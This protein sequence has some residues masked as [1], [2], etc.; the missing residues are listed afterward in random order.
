MFVARAQQ[1]S[2]KTY[3]A[4]DTLI[5]SSNSA[6]LGPCTIDT[7]TEVTCMLINRMTVPNVFVN[8]STIITFLPC[9]SPISVRIDAATSDVTILNETFSE[10][11]NVM[12]PNNPIFIEMF[13]V[14]LNQIDAGISFGVS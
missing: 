14:M 2:N 13:N 12:A 5:S 9:Q 3:S 6:F 10:S 7:H 11:Q 4:L 8:L 1:Q